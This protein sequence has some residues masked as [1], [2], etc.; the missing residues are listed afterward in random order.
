MPQAQGQHL[1]PAII[2]PLPQG[3]QRRL[4]P[5]RGRLALPAGLDLRE[6]R[7]DKKQHQHRQP[8]ADSLHP[9]HL[10]A[11]PSCRLNLCPVARYWV[12]E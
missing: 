10:T 2:V 6:K 5:L 9:S 1:R 4:Q 3:I 8:K 7:L 11:A 12:T